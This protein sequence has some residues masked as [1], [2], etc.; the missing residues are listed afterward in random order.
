[1]TDRDFMEASAGSRL[2]LIAESFARLTGRALVPPG[3]DMWTMRRAVVAHGTEDVP[4]FFYGNALALEL[5]AIS[6]ERFVG[7]PSHESAEP[8]QRAER[9]AMLEGLE[10][11]NVVADYSGVRIAANGRRFWIDRAVVWNLL[12]Q[13]DKRHGQA[14]TFTDWSPLSGGVFP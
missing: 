12:D 13:D 3:E 14:A 6:A 11:A 2:A 10:R 8:A 5:F 9:S 7:L 4:L 1:M